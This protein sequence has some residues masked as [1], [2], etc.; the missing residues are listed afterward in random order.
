[1]CRLRCFSPQA[2]SNRNIPSCDGASEIE[3]VSPPP[4]LLGICDSCFRAET[5]CLLEITIEY[6]GL[7]IIAGKYISLRFGFIPCFQAGL[8]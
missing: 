5:A 3:L 7:H 1:A 2:H 6:T 4:G 8:L